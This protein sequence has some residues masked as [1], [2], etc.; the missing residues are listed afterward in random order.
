MKQLF[1]KVDKNGDGDLSWEEF[2]AV[3]KNDWVRTWLSAMDLDITHAERLWRLMDDGD[4]KMTA[5]ELVKGIS[6]LKG[7]SK[8]IDLLHLAHEIGLIASL[9]HDIRE[10]V[11]KVT[12]SDR[13]ASRGAIYISEGRANVS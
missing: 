12:V 1:S 5:D 13:Q 8:S 2:E 11:H 6:R 4:N 9:L 3:T 10:T 7:P